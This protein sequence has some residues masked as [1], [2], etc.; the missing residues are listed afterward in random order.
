M[1]L[2]L[3]KVELAALKRLPIA[4]VGEQ[5]LHLG[6]SQGAKLFEEVGAPLSH[7]LGEGRL[8]VGEEKERTRGVKLLALEQQRRLW[9]Q[10]QQ[11]GHGPVP[12]GAGELMI[13]QAP[14]A[15]GYL[16]VVLREVHNGRGR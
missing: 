16:V 8:V 7:Q 6:T 2:A 4:R 12:A 14:A 9:P 10:Q 3:R 5:A 1:F 15:V 11:G 13:P